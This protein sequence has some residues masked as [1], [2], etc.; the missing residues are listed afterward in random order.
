MSDKLMQALTAQ[1]VVSWNKLQRKLLL[2]K[3]RYV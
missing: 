3:Y 1:T 2:D